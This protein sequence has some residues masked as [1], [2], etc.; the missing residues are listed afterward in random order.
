MHMQRMLHQKDN[1]IASLKV[2]CDRK[3]S[4]CQGLQDV[5]HDMKIKNT[6][7]HRE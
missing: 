6:D 2:E 7:L 5:I 1:E 3:E 4:E